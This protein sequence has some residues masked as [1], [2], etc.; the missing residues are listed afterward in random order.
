MV[1]SQYKY[2]IDATIPASK[3]DAD[4]TWF[5]I[6]FQINSSSGVSNTDLRSG[7]S[8]SANRADL[9]HTLGVLGTRYL[10]TAIRSGNWNIVDGT[11]L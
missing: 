5:P 8:N 3:V 6:L 7:G 11:V 9:P 2:V 1:L 10:K 4:L